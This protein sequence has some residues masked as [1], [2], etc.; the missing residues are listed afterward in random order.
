MTL[1]SLSALGIVTAAVVYI[2]AFLAHVAE[3]AGLRGIGDDPADDAPDGVPDKVREAEV[4]AETWGRMGLYLTVIGAASQ[5]VGVVCRGLAAH[6][7]PWGNMYEFVTAALFFVVVA[8][9]LLMTRRNVRWLGIGVTLLL[10]IGNGLAATVLYVGLAP[11][12]PALHSVWFV[13]HIVAACLAAAALNVGAI[14]SVLF[15]VK[16]RAERRAARTGTP[17]RGFLAR[18][19]DS[20]S[21]DNLAYR[22]HAFGF[23]IWTFTIAAGSIWAEYA[24]G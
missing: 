20:R 2:L 23:P 21:I 5:G 8:Y 9:L 6:R 11:L 7:L 12:V 14:A 10:A 15:L 3:W 18:V 4:R 13:V 22:A 1:A 24:W 17:L 19:P 16:Q